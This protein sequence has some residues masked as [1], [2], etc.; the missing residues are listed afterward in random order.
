MAIDI[1][2]SEMLDGL[3]GVL[4]ARYEPQFALGNAA[5]TFMMLPYIRAVW[6]QSSVNNA[7]NLLDAS[8]QG[9]TLSPGTAPSWVVNGLVPCVR[10]TRAGSQFLMRLDEAGLD[11]SP[12]ITVMTW[13]K[14]T[15]AST[16]NATGILAKWTTLGNFRSYALYKSAANAITFSISSLGT[17]VTVVSVAAPAAVYT[18]ANW[19]FLAGRFRVGAAID[20]FVSGTWYTQA[21]ILAAIFNS[22]AQ[23]EMGAMNGTDFLDAD[24]SI[25]ALC[26]GAL[27]DAVI[28]NAWEQTRAMF[29][30]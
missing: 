8:D 13:I 24:M 10:F 6:L 4:Q 7:N 15:A 29:G 2:N 11:I 9:R 18:T 3:K 21:T 17:A 23:L 1:Y 19:L 27:P 5:G 28:R 20:L 26:A 30:V 22:T 25:T 16:G 12:E 14:F